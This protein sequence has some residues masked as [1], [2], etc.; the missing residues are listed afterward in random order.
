MTVVAVHTPTNWVRVVD[1]LRQGER[2]VRRRFA[3]RRTFEGSL[4]GD[5][6]ARPR[7]AGR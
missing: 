5:S 3:L 1:R 4:D 7:A 6:G 2:Q